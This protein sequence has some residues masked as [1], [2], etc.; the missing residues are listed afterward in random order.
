MEERTVTGVS[1]GLT[2]IMPLSNLEETGQLI[3]NG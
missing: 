2:V 3:L 1:E